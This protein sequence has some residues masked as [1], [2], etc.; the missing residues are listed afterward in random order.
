MDTENQEIQGK[1]TKESDERGRFIHYGG[2][3]LDCF[4]VDSLEW[5]LY[6]QF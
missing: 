3:G 2:F 6:K 5:V 4:W 1:E